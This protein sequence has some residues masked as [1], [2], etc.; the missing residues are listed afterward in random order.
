MTNIMID[1]QIVVF[2]IKV[3]C[4]NELVSNIYSID[5]YHILI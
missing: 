5:I 3:V 4:K 1:I 2:R